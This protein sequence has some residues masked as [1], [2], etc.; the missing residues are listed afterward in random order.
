MKKNAGA[1]R[2]LRARGAA[3]VA[4]QKLIRESRSY[5]ITVRSYYGDIH[6]PDTIENDEKEL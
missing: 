1:A 4:L 6:D 5:W 3:A 2:E